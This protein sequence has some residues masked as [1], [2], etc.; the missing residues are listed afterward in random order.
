MPGK[1][2][3]ERVGLPAIALTTDT[4]ALTAISNDY[5]FDNVF[6]RQVDALARRG[7][8]LVAISTSGNSPNVIAAVMA[9]RSKGCKVIGLTGKNGKKL[10]GLCDACILVPAERTARIQEVHITIAHI[11]CEIIDRKIEDGDLTIPA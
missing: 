2:V 6:A 11:W 1:D 5:Q 7:D 4:S 8:C 10:A 3:V 9:A